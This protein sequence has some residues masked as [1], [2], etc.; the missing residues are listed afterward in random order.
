[1][2]LDNINSHSKAFSLIAIAESKSFMPYSDLSDN[3][4]LLIANGGLTSGPKF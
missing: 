2:S 3:F 4:R 1:M